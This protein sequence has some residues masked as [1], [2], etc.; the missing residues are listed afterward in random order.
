M[1][2]MPVVMMIMMALRWLSAVVVPHHREGRP[3]LNWSVG[4][5][6]DLKD[7]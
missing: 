5:R 4:K 3:Q 6:V 1:V 2:L 7:L